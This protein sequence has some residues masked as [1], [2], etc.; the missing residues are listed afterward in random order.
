MKPYYEEDGITIYHGDCREVL[1]RLT[2][3]FFGGVLT[4]PPYNRGDMS[5]GYANLSDGY[6]SYEDRMPHAE[7]VAWQRSLL[8]ECWELLRPTGAILYN[9]KPRIQDGLLWTPLELNPGLPLR[10][11]IMWTRPAGC[12]WSETHLMPR[13]EWI[14]L[15][16]KSEFRFSKATS[17]LSDVWPI[18]HQG[19]GR[20]DHPAPFPLALAHRAVSLLRAASPGPVLD[21][22]MGSGTTLRAAKNL[23]SPAIGIEVSERYCEIAAK[24]LAQGVLSFGESA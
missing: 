15:F 8:T 18:N 3:G 4:S 16:A 20:P 5:G 24:R 14:L 10:Q 11:I 1:P 21:P 2:P 19:G 23:W 22:F 9:H 13:H 6:A 12:N 17:S 7:Y